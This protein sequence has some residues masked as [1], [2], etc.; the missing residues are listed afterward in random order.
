MSRENIGKLLEQKLWN[1]SEQDVDQVVLKC[2]DSAVVIKISVDILRKWEPEGW[3]KE[4]EGWNRRF[5][6]EEGPM[7]EDEDKK[8]EYEAKRREYV[9][10]KR[11]KARQIEEG[12]GEYTA[13]WADMMRNAKED[14]KP[15]YYW[16]LYTGPDTILKD[17]KPDTGRGREYYEKCIELM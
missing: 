9:A 6:D 2:R 16:T 11:E 3:N 14:W 1:L 13:E 5:V 4:P 10:K 12:L 7:P 17:W 15:E 8:K